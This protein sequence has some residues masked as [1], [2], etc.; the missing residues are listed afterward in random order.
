MQTKPNIVSRAAGH[1]PPLSGNRNTDSRRLVLRNENPEVWA[2]H[3][4]VYT[5]RY[6]PTDI[7]EEELVEDIAFC[8]WRLIRFRTVENALWDIQLEDDDRHL[9]EADA[10]IDA[11]VRL[12]TA[13]RRDEHINNVASRYEARLRRSYN[14]AIRDLE[15]FRATTGANPVVD[16]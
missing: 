11:G 9:T 3:L 2:R 7:I 5:D 12:A 15:Q 10:N 13:F 1:R 14:R 4:A 6:K 8:R 16:K